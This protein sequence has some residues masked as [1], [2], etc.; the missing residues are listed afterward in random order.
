MQ[1]DKPQNYIKESST[2]PIRSG[3]KTK[4]A[5]GPRSMVWVVALSILLSL[6]V[7]IMVFT[8]TDEVPPS[9]PRGA[10]GSSPGQG[11]Q[12][13]APTAEPRTNQ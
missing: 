8:N 9:D 2:G 13:N 6:I 1:H 10:I 11:A 5:G 12:P 3:A 7:G 4:Q